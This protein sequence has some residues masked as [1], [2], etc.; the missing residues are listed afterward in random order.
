MCKYN[1]LTPSGKLDMDR[2][3]SWASTELEKINSSNMLDIEKVHESQKILTKTKE[4]MGKI[5]GTSA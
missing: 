4:L 5:L 3:K 1:D 2:I